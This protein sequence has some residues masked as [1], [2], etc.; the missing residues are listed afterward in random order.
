MSQNP[1]EFPARNH[2]FSEERKLRMNSALLDQPINRECVETE[3][4][5]RL[6]D[7][8]LVAFDCGRVLPFHNENIVLRSQKGVRNSGQTLPACTFCPQ[9]F[10][11]MD[12][13]TER[14]S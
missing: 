2:Q 8:A 7:G 3:C 13:D 4:I 11:N 10:W 12:A 1:V 5:C 6:R 14:A 9:L